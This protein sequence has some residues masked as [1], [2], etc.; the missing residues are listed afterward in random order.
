MIQ[1][2]AVDL[3]LLKIQTLDYAADNES[4]WI[5]FKEFMQKHDFK[6]IEKN[7][8]MNACIDGKI[9]SKTN[10]ISAEQYYNET[11]GK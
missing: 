9:I 4:A 10:N 7:Q 3:I 1:K 6:E 8:I 11:Y 2:T 5:R